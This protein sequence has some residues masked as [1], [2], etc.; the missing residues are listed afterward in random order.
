MR[1][2]SKAKAV[3]SHLLGT[4]P[5]SKTTVDQDL[6]IR[7]HSCRLTEHIGRKSK[8]EPPKPHRAFSYFMKC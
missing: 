3:G 2:F 5:L 7:E 1:D 4:W 6:L 8:G